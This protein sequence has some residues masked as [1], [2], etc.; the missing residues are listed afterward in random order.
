MATR[1]TDLL[2]GTA[3]GKNNKAYARGRQTPMINLKN[4]GQFG[5]TPDYQTL[6]SSQPYVRGQLVAKLL[7]APRGFDLLPEP[8]YWYETLKALVETHPESWEGLNS[9]FTVEHVSAGFGGAGEEIE[10]ESDFKRERSAPSA[11]YTEKRGKVIQTFWEMY[12]MMLMGTPETKYPLVTTLPRGKEY[13]GM[14]DSKSFTVLFFEPDRN[15]TTVVDAWLCAGMRP[16]GAGTRE[17][18]RDLRSGMELNEF[19]VEFTA[20][21]QVGFGVMNLA[22]SLM[23][24][25]NM[26]GASPMARPAYL[27]KVQAEVSSVT[28]TGYSEQIAAAARS[29]VQV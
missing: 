16:K 27:D 7:S 13:D 17:G 3:D 24:Q 10:E 5:Y 15:G 26:T 29:S 21:T 12:A 14:I 9:T 6:V 20:I 25:M 11:K 8:Q 28:S 1:P 2:L 22:Q 23:D 4:G 19:N 18:R